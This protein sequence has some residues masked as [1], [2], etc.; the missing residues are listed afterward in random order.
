M[1]PFL[2][3]ILAICKKSNNERTVRRRNRQAW[4]PLEVLEERLLLSG[5]GLAAPSPNWLTP[6]QVRGAYGFD[7][8]GNFLRTPSSPGFPSD[9]SG[10]TIAIVDDGDNQNVAN[11]LATFSDRFNLTPM[12][13]QNGHPW[14]RK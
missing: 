4:L 6:Q 10:Q 13:G 12:D 1:K 7:K 11:D 9:G 3:Q 8:I 2:K 5:T 14:F